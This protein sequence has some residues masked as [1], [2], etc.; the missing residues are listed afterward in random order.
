MRVVGASW[1]VAVVLLLQHF[2][3]AASREFGFAW[4]PD[5]RQTKYFPDVKQTLTDLKISRRQTDERFGAAVLLN[6]KNS[7]GIHR[8]H[9]HRTLRRWTTSTTTPSVTGELMTISLQNP[10][11][12]NVF[13][14]KSQR[15]HV[16]GRRLL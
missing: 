9:H 16:G 14:W 15:L 6:A 13:W 3:N 2:R 7:D 12:T 10:T 5:A 1:V 4:P 8:H 11:A